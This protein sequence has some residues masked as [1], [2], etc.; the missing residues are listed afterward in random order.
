MSWPRMPSRRFGPAQHIRIEVVDRSAMAWSTAS[1]KRMTSWTFMSQADR[2][3]A[4]S[5][6]DALVR[7]ARY[8]DKLL[9]IEARSAHGGWRGSCGPSSRLPGAPATVGARTM[10][11]QT[12]PSAVWELPEIRGRSTAG[13]GA[14]VVPEASPGHRGLR[15][16]R[17]KSKKKARGGFGVSERL[18]HS[19][20]NALTFRSAG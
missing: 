15:P 17:E 6:S 12:A 18:S 14:R 4:Q 9:D 16:G 5:R 10:D 11:S 19:W 1:L 13:S 8:S 3:P 20:K 2:Y 7:S